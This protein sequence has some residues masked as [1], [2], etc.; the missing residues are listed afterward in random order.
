MTARQ[1]ILIT[2][3]AIQNRV[4]E[5]A[6]Q[7]RKDFGDEPVLLLCV[8]K[9]AFPFLA[10]LCRLIGG[11]I[12]VDFVQIS[13]YGDDKSSSGVV[14][15]KKDHDINIENR[16][17]VVV[18]DIVDTGL[19]LKHL[20]ELLA[21]RKPKALKVAAILSKPDAH[22]YQ[23]PVDYLGFEIPDKFVVGYGLDY[24]ERYRQ[25]PFIAV[26]QGDKA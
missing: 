9:G 14:R 17:V 3:E 21:T 22:Q 15:L 1:E 23:V 8:L 16:N 6:A 26:L 5:L 2:E 10:D 7:I 25:L 11:E 12:M 13:S 24:A 19:T 20:L 4:K 18:E